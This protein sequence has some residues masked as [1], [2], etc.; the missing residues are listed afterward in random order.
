MP[1]RP[2]PAANHMNVLYQS[3]LMHVLAHGEKVSPRGQETLE[4]R[5][6]VFT[7]LNA[8]NSLVT[9][10]SRKMNLTFS[11]VESLQLIA[12]TSDS[13][14]QIRFNSNMANFV[15]KATNQ[16]EAPYGLALRE[17]LIPTI[18][19]LKRDPDTRRA[20]ITIY[21]GAQMQL[22]RANVPCTESLQF[23]IRDGKLE[24][25]VMMRSN[26]LWWGV[27]YDVAQFTA[28]QFVVAQA[29]HLP[30]GAYHHIAASGHI[31]EPMYDQA[32]K[33]ATEQVSCS[34]LWDSQSPRFGGFGG[35]SYLNTI[36]EARTIL[37][38]ERCA[39]RLDYD[40]LYPIKEKAALLLSLK[41]QRNLASLLG[42]KV[43]QK[44][45]SKS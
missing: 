24:L 6:L 36:E 32:H 1:L 2:P 26:D 37:D 16:F 18:D 10:P 13:D 40:Y 20:V 7:L 11:L 5:P 41:G 34:F 31:Y 14:Q 3:L 25:T 35:D 42:Y 23:F 28:V 12:M 19:A 27:P 9:L 38:F 29:L 43:K 21:E 44:E 22:S 8:S 30:M 15:D 45:R 39:Y 17:Q 4:V 33:V